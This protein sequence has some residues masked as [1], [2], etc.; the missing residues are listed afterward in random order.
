MNMSTDWDSLFVNNPSLMWAFHLHTLRF[1]DV[2]HA[3]LAWSGY[4]RTEFLTLRLHDIHPPD[5]VSMLCK[6]VAADMEPLYVQPIRLGV[7]PF[8]K[9]NGA[10]AFVRVMCQPVRENTVYLQAK[11][12]RLLGPA[13]DMFASATSNG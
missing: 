4:R 10:F 12:E 7:I 3:V 2:N 13:S 11:E 1:V 9:K 8:R 5:N 6:R